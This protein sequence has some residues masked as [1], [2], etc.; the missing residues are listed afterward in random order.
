MKTWYSHKFKY[1][2]VRYEV[3]LSILKGDIVWINGPFPAGLYPDINIFREN[4]K[5][6]LDEDERVVADD[7]YIGE[8][9][10]YVKCPAKTFQSNPEMFQYVRA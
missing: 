3:G 10:G 6:A 2:A 7:G 4:L 8:A 5:G 1:S 9:P